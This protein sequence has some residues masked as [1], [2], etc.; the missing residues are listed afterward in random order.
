MS[1]ISA[2]TIMPIF[3]A[4]SEEQRH[5]FLEK[6]KKL[7]QKKDKPIKKKKTVIDRVCEQLGEQFRPGNEEMLIAHLMHEK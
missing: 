3:L 2:D 1:S 6:A 5:V 7:T 4:L